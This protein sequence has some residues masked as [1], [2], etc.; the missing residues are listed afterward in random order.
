MIHIPPG[1]VAGR[2][3][4]PASK[5]HLQRLILAAALAD[6]ESVLGEPGQSADGRACLA[7]ARA[8]GAEVEE[9]PRQLRIRGGGPVR[10][11]RL[12]C[13]ES[14]FCLRAAAAVA[15]LWDGEFTLEG[16]G[17]L[18]SRPVDMVLAPLGQLGVAAS[19]REGHPPVTVRG[20]LRGGRAVVDGSSS[21]QFLSGLL[22]AL[23]RAAG[24]SQLEVRG[25]R[26]GAYVRMTLEVLAA[27]GAQVEA[28]TD[29]SWYRMQGGQRYRP[30][31]LAV[32]GDWSGA[33]F[34]LVAGAVAGE[35]TVAGL[36]PGSVQPDRAV[37][38][39][40]EAA[41]AHV[42]WQ[43]GDL[44]V[45]RGEL[46]A[47]SFD[48]TDCP[49]LFPPLAALACHAQGTSRIAG[50]ARL[51]HKESDRG[52]ALVSE[53]TALG[54]RVAVAGAV[55]EITGGPLPGGRLDPHN[56]HRMAMAGAVAALG[57]R[58]GVTMAGEGCVAKSYPDFFQAL[59]SLRG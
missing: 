8:L 6:G 44:R 57:S 4:A 24:D 19:T 23:P 37:L 5:S 56:D 21:S 54:A 48:A 26:S 31:D 52:A 1:P 35:V 43:G 36:D 51:A 34:L 41:G 13:G 27:F 12:P 15:G 40:L 30:V 58:D 49:D 3:R 33:A 45:A 25:L 29:G 14:G 59:A 17:S 7:V 28:A 2:L 10:G 38:E 39:A 9:S 32:E 46:R 47:F 22:L 42:A 18:A 11:R 16:E 20:P 50:V 55:L 53:L